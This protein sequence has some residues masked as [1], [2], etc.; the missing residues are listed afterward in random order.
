MYQPTFMYKS[1][2]E[3]GFQDRE[4]TGRR[5]EEGREAYKVNVGQQRRSSGPDTNTRNIQQ[6]G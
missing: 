5:G 4:V 2:S 1:E 3:R 6:E